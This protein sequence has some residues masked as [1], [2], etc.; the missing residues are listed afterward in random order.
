M[1]RQEFGYGKGIT[2]NSAFLV[3]DIIN[4]YMEMGRLFSDGKSLYHVEM[5]DEEDIDRDSVLPE[6]FSIHFLNDRY[7]LIRIG[8]Y[9]KDESEY[10]EFRLF[11]MDMN[12]HVENYVY[13]IETS[14]CSV[15]WRKL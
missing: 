6:N 4:D 10:T 8:G 14:P 15:F 2:D 7:A 12:E 1:D 5:M 3:W 13:S 11:D 9:L